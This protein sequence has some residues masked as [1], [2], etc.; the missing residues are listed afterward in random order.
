MKKQKK[1]RWFDRIGAYRIFGIPL[2]TWLFIFSIFICFAGSFYFFIIHESNTPPTSE[3][4]VAEVSDKWT[5]S[6]DDD[7]GG[8]IIYHVRLKQNEKEFT[9][10]V[11]SILIR[12]W[13][14]LE[15]GKKYQLSVNRTTGGRCYV[16]EA[17]QIKETPPPFWLDK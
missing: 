12:L 7:S 3:I 2:G 13:Y 11:S 15:T 16:Y 4:F 6:Y 8:Y 10:S 5:T 14:Q 9:C 17:A 1:Q